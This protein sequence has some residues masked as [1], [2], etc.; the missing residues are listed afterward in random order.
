MT[1]V[2]I[3]AVV[4]GVLAGYWV[5]PPELAV[6]GDQ[7]TTVGLCLII[8]LVGVDMG[9]QGDAL[10][11]IKAAGWRVLLIPVAVVIGTLGGGLVAGLILPLGIKDAVLVS[12]GFGWYSLAPILLAEYSTSLSAVAF[13]SN[14]MRELL[15]IL[16]IPLAAKY[17]GYLEPVGLAGAA[18]M[19][20]LLPVV[21]SATHERIFIYSFVSGMVL[22]MLM[23]LLVPA[24]ILL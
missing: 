1:L 22:T 9:K 13:L 11:S 24:L 8:F 21:L 23:P 7:L 4:L 6:Y 17:L 2:I 16:F 14:I 19:D 3:G 5:I 18:A 10:E 20:T 15:A 12:A